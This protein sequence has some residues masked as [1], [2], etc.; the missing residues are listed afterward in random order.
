MKKEDLRQYIRALK[1]Q[2]SERQLKEMSEPIIQR[3]LSLPAVARAGVILMYYS[4]PDEVNTHSA[5]NTLVTKGKT[6]LLPVVVSH[7]EM[8]LRVYKS[9]KDMET[10]FF[11]IMEPVGELFTDYEQ[12]DVAVIPGMGFDTQGNRLGRGKG[13][14]D[15]FLSKHPHIYRIGVCYDFQKLPGIPTDEH[16]IK[17]NEVV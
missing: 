15:R 14:Y 10:G 5:I 6:V 8:E 9:E 11:N 13:Y 7:D 2:F 4:L 1:S 12:I 17:M 3:L 16:D